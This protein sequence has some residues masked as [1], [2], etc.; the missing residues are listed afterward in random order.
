MQKRFY[1]Y[2]EDTKAVAF[3]DILGFSNLT[4]IA[5]IDGLMPSGTTFSVFE[6]CILPYRKSMLQVF[7]RQVHATVGDA[8]QKAGFWHKELPVGAI[9][10]VYASDCAVFYS[11]SLTHLFREISAIFGAAI[12]WGVPLRGAI[13]TGSLHHSEWVERPGS[14]ICLYG[15]ALSRAADLEKR[16]SGCGMRVWLDETVSPYLEKYDELKDITVP[17]SQDLPGELRWWLQA[18]N[19][20]DGQ[21]ESEVLRHKFAR[22]KTEKHV[23]TWFAGP[24]AESTTRVIARAIDELQ[25]LG[26]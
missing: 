5:R 15:D 18:V 21:T 7:P 13:A 26:R 10:F 11:H 19:P 2:D 9:N 4:K 8:E 23:S 20:T 1:S 22:W 6:N 12:V 17:A 16:V 3:V 24:N 14:A 25:H